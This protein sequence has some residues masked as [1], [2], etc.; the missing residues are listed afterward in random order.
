MEGKVC[1]F[2][3]MVRFNLCVRIFWVELEKA[4]HVPPDFVFLFSSG[5]LN[6]CKPGCQG[7]LSACL[8]PCPVTCCNKRFQIPSI[9]VKR[10]DTEI[11]PV[12][13]RSKVVRQ[14]C[15]CVMEC[16][17]SASVEDNQKC[18]E[19]CTCHKDT[20]ASTAGPG[21]DSKNKHS[22]KGRK[23]FSR[24]HIGKS[25][26]DKMKHLFTKWLKEYNGIRHE[27]KPHEQKMSKSET[28]KD[29]RV[30]F[31]SK[32]LK[33]YQYFRQKE[34]ALRFLQQQQNEL[35]GQQQHLEDLLTKQ[36]NV[37]SWTGS[38][39]DKVPKLNQTKSGPRH[40]TADDVNITI[41][42][43]NTT[44]A[45]PITTAPNV[46]AASLNQQTL[47]EIEGIKTQIAEI[48]SQQEFLSKQQIQLADQLEAERALFEEAR[49]LI[50]LVVEQNKG[51][52][53]GAAPAAANTPTNIP[54]ESQFEDALNPEALPSNIEAVRDSSLLK[55]LQSVLS[56]LVFS[57]NTNQPEEYGDDGQQM[58]FLQNDLEDEA[59]QNGNSE[60]AKKA[61]IDPEVRN[62]MY[63]VPVEIDRSDVN[64]EGPK[65]YL[66]GRNSFDNADEDGNAF[67]MD[68]DPGP[69]F[70]VM[71]KKTLHPHDL[72]KD[73]HNMSERLKKS[74]PNHKTKATT[75]H[76]HGSLN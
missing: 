57:G 69:D 37:L 4:Y 19:K 67:V 14:S 20:D 18:H 70:A 34:K 12:S 59:N 53:G 3:E 44:K 35:V 76:V 38:P 41:T 63:K 51:R 2:Y 73:S 42:T 68:D 27:E 21:K 16:D 40:T 7:P 54:K 61:G 71:E 62:P 11:I 31:I 8:P 43:T 52:G 6:L 45:P 72:L 64:A 66:F 74:G 26:M 65:N 50:H 48:R 58:M 47:A 9:K 22:R 33:N 25:E 28:L 46:G 23:K 49:K 75:S 24:P 5:P 15:S 13:E 55:K 39:H 60:F 36:E 56:R 10:S 32:M 17:G 30:G 29:G 1:S